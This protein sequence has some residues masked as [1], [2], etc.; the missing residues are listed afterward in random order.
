MYCRM[1]AQVFMAMMARGV[2]RKRLFAKSRLFL[3]GHGTRSRPSLRTQPRWGACEDIG[4]C[5]F[6]SGSEDP[7]ATATDFKD[8]DEV[9]WCRTFLQCL[10]PGMV[11]AIQA[12][13]SAPPGFTTAYSGAGFFES[14]M[15]QV[16]R[17]LGDRDGAVPK[18]WHACEIDDLPRRILLQHEDGPTAPEC[19]F[20]DLTRRVPA[21]TMEKLTRIQENL[22]MEFE[23]SSQDLDAKTKRAMKEEF[24]MRIFELCMNALEN[25]VVHGEDWCYKHH[26][27]CRFVEACGPH[28][29]QG[30]SMHCAGSCCYEF[31]S[32]TTEKKE[33]T[34]STIITFAVWLHLRRVAQEAV[35]LHECVPKH[36]GEALIT[37]VLG[38][39][40]HV[41]SF[42][43]CPSM[44][45]FP[46]TRKRRFTI[47]IH[48]SFMN[49]IFETRLTSRKNPIVEAFGGAA[50]ET[51]S[52]AAAYFVATEAELQSIFTSE[53]RR[54]RKLRANS[55]PTLENVGC[56]R[57]LMKHLEEHGC[58]SDLFVD[59]TQDCNRGDPRKTIGCL[60]RRS[61][62][63]SM[64]LNRPI[65]GLEKL[66]LMGNGLRVCPFRDVVPHLTEPQLA[67]LTGNAFHIPTVGAVMFWA[68]SLCRS[69]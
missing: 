62:W 6:G 12:A 10:D 31:S 63:W 66:Q 43:V 46:C 33:L 13:F 16:G 45:G 65:V 2:K 68:L 40:H 11:A 27:T 57:R 26:R 22:R 34:G 49:N 51:D 35:V 8:L 37:T 38:S 23:Q 39:T 28:G 24:G 15:S 67:S 69:A 9:K 54:R 42:C 30:I 29:H 64:R 58:D 14:L 53:A 44:L 50:K 47:A 52:S 3:H 41:R 20:G 21:A 32:M 59:I 56:R 18:C 19:I 48:R 7:A 60:L 1:A 61:V 5:E 25:E 4:H 36:P 55:W 17:V